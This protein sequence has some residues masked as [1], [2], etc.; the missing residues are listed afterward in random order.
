MW[1]AYD[2]KRS[3]RSFSLKLGIWSSQ[4]LDF[5]LI[6]LSFLPRFCIMGNSN[7]SFLIALYWNNKWGVWSLKMWNNLEATKNWFKVQKWILFS[8]YC[9]FSLVLLSFSPAKLDV[10]VWHQKLI[11]NLLITK[12]SGCISLRVSGIGHNGIKTSGH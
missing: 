6:V 10:Q 7:V 11:S 4:F 12:L 9:L 5:P 3:C 1:S 8:E 2:F